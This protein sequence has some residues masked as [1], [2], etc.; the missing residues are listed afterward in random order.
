MGSKED[1]CCLFFPEVLLMTENEAKEVKI[2][3][4]DFVQRKELRMFLRLEDHP[5]WS[6][7]VSS[8]CKS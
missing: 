1:D 7:G 5:T 4:L 2:E 6:Q 3:E 8:C